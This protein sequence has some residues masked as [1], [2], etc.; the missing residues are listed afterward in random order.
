MNAGVVT[1]SRQFKSESIVITFDC[2][3]EE[4]ID[5]S[6]EDMENQGKEEDDEGP[7]MAVGINFD[8]TITSKD[9]SKMVVDCTA[10]QDLMVNQ[11]RYVDSGKDVTD[12]TLYGGPVF[13]QLDDKLVDAFYA[14]LDDRKINADLCYFICAHAGV[15]EQK[16]YVNWL[17]KLLNFV[18]K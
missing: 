12:T 4:E 2:Q 8:I 3:D 6:A 5:P 15:K 14:Y 11:V 1:L 10:T 9:G 13:D 17:N 18:E 7:E 16:E